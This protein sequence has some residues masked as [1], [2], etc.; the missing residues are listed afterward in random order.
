M[1]LYDRHFGADLL[2]LGVKRI[3][4]LTE[5]PPLS[6][7]IHFPW[8]LRKCPYCDFNSHDC[9]QKE[10]PFGPYRQ[11]LQAD[12]LQTLPMVSGREVGSI[13]I[14]GGTPSLMPASDV[15]ALL[16]FIDKHFALKENCE[17][18]LEANP[19]TYEKQNFLALCSAGINRLSLGVQSFNNEKLHVLGR[20]H[21]SEQAIAAIEEVS[22]VF[23]QWN[24]DLMYALPKQDLH[25]LSQD[26]QFALSFQPP[27]LSVYH[28]TIEANTYFAKRPP[29][30]LPDEDLAFDMLDLITEKTAKAGMSRYEV[31]AFSKPGCHCQHNLNYWRFGDYVGIGAGAHGKISFNDRVTRQ[32]KFRSPA[33]YMENALAGHALSHQRVVHQDELAF[34][35]M[36][37]ALRLKKG[38][39][40][41][42]FEK[43]TGLPIHFIHEPLERAKAL[44]LLD[45]ENQ[46]IKASTKG[47]DFLS[48]LI[49][50]FLP[51]SIG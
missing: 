13:F 51:V 1:N 39:S 42:L 30:D 36:L 19:G 10:I 7:Y 5:L 11:A 43:R 48:D 49:E 17:I 32:I 50:L 27:H 9:V 35:F 12:L 25:G 15:E 16:N 20:I 18:T 22:Q 21:T 41:S 33:L 24:L 45:R 44:G 28:L 2:S 26:L 47:F 31:S 37:G 14:G 6:L 23:Q 3:L 8:C 40:E 29:I 34:E 38:F 4:A 46:W